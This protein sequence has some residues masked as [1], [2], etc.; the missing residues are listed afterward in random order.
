MYWG[1]L[2]KYEMSGR[3]VRKILSYL[4]VT[5]SCSD[6]GFFTSRVVVQGD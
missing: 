6:L 1:L 3:V 2:V 4:V 5:L